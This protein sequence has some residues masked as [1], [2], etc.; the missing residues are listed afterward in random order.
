MILSKCIDY[1]QQK[2]WER[3]FRTSA[4]V[5]VINTINEQESKFKNHFEGY[6]L[7]DVYPYQ[8]KNK[9]DDEN[10]TS[11]HFMLVEVVDYTV[12][13]C[14]AGTMLDPLVVRTKT[15]MDLSDFRII[16]KYPVILKKRTATWILYGNINN[17]GGFT[18]MNRKKIMNCRLRFISD[19]YMTNQ[20]QQLVITQSTCPTVNEQLY[21]HVVYTLK[22]AQDTISTVSNIYIII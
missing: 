19:V 22:A 8:M 15:F 7:G 4:N 10:N 12:I 6:Q 14:D 17:E 20:T 13:K 18:E 11:S 1:R 21:H 2:E 3:T 16:R 9:A 5:S